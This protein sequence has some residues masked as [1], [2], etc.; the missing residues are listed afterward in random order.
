MSEPN[1]QPAHSDAAVPN[2]PSPKQQH[3]ASSPTSD[4]KPRKARPRW[5]RRI[6]GGVVVLATFAVVLRV[7]LHFAL[8]SVIDKVAARYGLKV[9]FERQELTL[10]GGDA[11]LWFVK[12]TPMAGGEPV[13][14][15]DYV[16]GDISVVQLLM[17]RLVVWRV[18]G[19]GVELNI[20][21][22]ADGRI[23]LLE[24]FVSTNTK[25]APTPP[26]AASK[27]AGD[28]KKQIEFSSP[29]RVDALRLNRVRATIRDKSVSPEFIATVGM[30]V[31]VSDV[32]SKNRP[33]KFELEVM[34]DPLLDLLHVEG[35]ARSDGPRKLDAN[36]MVT[37]RGLHLRPAEPYLLP[38]GLRP[39][40]DSMTAQMKARLSTEAL[41]DPAKGVSATL[42][43]EEIS[44]RS[45][46]SEAAA[47]DKVELKADS[48]D[49]SAAKLASLLVDG[50]RLN[51]S[52]SADGTLRFAGIEL[53]PATPAASASLAES[54]P[55]VPP[56]AGPTTRPVPYQ[57]R[58]A[59]LR[60]SNVTAR[61]HDAAVSPPAELALVV[62][63]L[64]SKDVP[65]D[66]A[67]PEAT[68]AVS[69]TFSVP[70]VVKQIQLTGRLKPYAPR[71]S[72]QMSIAG[73]GVRPDA[74]RP[75][76]DALGIESTIQSGKFAASVDAAV[77]LESTGKVVAD[78]ILSDV[79]LTDIQELI[80]MKR[81][82]IDSISIDPQRD[83]LRVESI[84]VAGPSLA[85]A[86]EENGAI[87]AVG[88]RL[89]PRRPRPA[90]PAPGSAQEEQSQELNQRSINF[91]RIEIGELVWNG[92]KV[93]FTDD[94]AE[95]RRSLAIADAGVKLNNLVID[96]QPASEQAAA[97]GKFRAW[98]KSP[99]VAERL[100][101]SGELTPKPSG[102]DIT[103]D[104]TGEGLSPATL[105]PYL[106]P[107]GVEP[108]LRDG[109]LKLSTTVN[110]SKTDDA[111]AISASV[112]NLVYGTAGNELVGL[113]GLAISNLVL[114]SEG[115]SVDRIQV[116]RPRAR[117]VRDAAGAVEVA[118]VRIRS[119]ASSPYAPSTQPTIAVETLR[120]PA[121]AADAAPFE[122]PAVVLRELRLNDAAIAWSDHG[123]SPPVQTTI[124]ASARLD[125]FAIGQPTDDP[126]TFQV[127]VA[128]DG[129]MDGLTLAGRMN[130]SVDSPW[131]DVKIEAGGL[132]ASQL[133]AYLPAGAQVTL[134]DGRFRAAMEAGL[135]RQAEGGFGVR[136]IV[137][138]VDY[139]DGADGPPLFA[140]EGVTLAANRI[141]VPGGI[142]AIDEIS[143]AGVETEARRSTDGAI[144]LLGV[145]LRS[146][147]A[148]AP[149]TARLV[150]EPQ[151]NVAAVPAIQPAADVAQIVDQARKPMPTLTIGK[152]DLNLK[153]A[154]VYD[155]SRPDAAP[156]ALANW[157]LHTLAPI[158]A[159]GKN[160]EAAPPIQMELTGRVDPIVGSVAV[161]TQA[162]PFA[163]QPSAQVDVALTGIRGQGLTDLIPQLR[164]QLD[165][166]KLTDGQFRTRVEAAARFSRRGAGDLDLTRG[167]ELDLLV[168]DTAFRNG[169]DGP[170]LA[171]LESLQS[172]GIRVQPAS[173]SVHVKTLELTKPIGYVLRDNEGVHV[174]GWVVKLPKPA[175]NEEAPTL[176]AAE[177]SSVSAETTSVAASS[178][179][180]T[181]SSSS[182]SGEIRVDRLLVSG[183]DMTLEDRAVTPPMLVPLNGLDVEVRD[184]TNLALV[185]NRPIRFSAV[186]TAGKVALP[187]HVK[188]AG[189]AGAIGDVGAMLGGNKIEEAAVEL[190]QRDVF[191][192]I[193]GNGSISLYPAPAG[194]AKSSIS[195]LELAA[196]S[197]AASQAGVTL[198]DGVFDGTVDLRIAEDGN[199]DAKSK[200]VLTDLKMSEPENGPIARHIALPAPLDAVIGTVQD[201]GG[202]ITLP[203][204]VQVRQGELSGVGGAVAGAVS[205]VIATAFASAPAKAVGGV[206]D[207]VGLGGK[208]QDRQGPPPVVIAFAPADSALGPKELDQINAVVELMRKDESVQL[209]LKH[210]LGGG[211]VNL[212]HTRANPSPDD[213]LALAQKTRAHK[214]RLLQLRAQLIGQARSS[215]AVLPAAQADATLQQLREVEQELAHTEDALDELYG[216][217]RPGAD[218]QASRRTRVAALAIGQQRLEAVRASLNVNGVPH[219][220]ER[221]RMLNPQFATPEGD[222]AGQVV[223]T[224]VG[225]K[226]NRASGWMSF[227]RIPGLTK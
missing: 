222:D 14:A 44:A 108:T 189:I 13:L 7:A 163:Q 188:G 192:Q 103:A 83:L 202:A 186:L 65:L 199:I 5:R 174:L 36:M 128:V 89:D 153:R 138:D 17:G 139:R 201:S 167:F 215:L 56:T 28:A 158:E 26:N 118:G 30:D 1:A 24:Q 135:T 117:L 195:G 144:R 180:A 34:S 66:A 212:A 179:P 173:G 9:A 58:L 182:S 196:F 31:R 187:K 42:A 53:V 52:R 152:I 6:L 126:A 113:D 27:P 77:K 18:E 154:T 214:A 38:L 198:N 156:L 16:R 69:G 129:S 67:N 40:A 127:D 59:D 75:Y 148:E 93:D 49:F 32:G 35:E 197:G 136:L 106:Q 146:V 33:T 149:A 210:E 207:L 23:A 112:K 221:V 110:L 61:F 114:G 204:N 19:D 51:A 29:L 95:T 211:D 165:G 226:S 45:D 134:H 209:V 225:D 206:T 3:G 130:P 176:A 87:C 68:V 131:V 168:A 194:Y 64:T 71:K 151:P 2:G 119:A 125:E 140:L 86:R 11:G 8:P 121:S 48:V 105:A 107:F 41:A 100:E 220:A 170:V 81:M 115:T 72:L 102:L 111:F 47:V 62:N 200:F 99:G 80:A 132:R 223:V 224:F 90:S 213:C 73:E 15:A 43:L 22:S 133:A 216:M 39:T 122:L 57:V 116:D 85:V 184:L 88:F 109:A 171:G 97:P 227:L 54:E 21:R 219:A 92:V 4:A 82:A 203:V 91:P 60:V 147:P 79:M 70:N 159:G 98:L 177:V 55:A 94:A 123:V 145:E 84:E 190:E 37:M 155:D 120:G 142:F 74:I 205:S 25:P 175:A 162:A 78:A 178:E 160:A 166:A 12:V 46:S 150:A 101:A 208:E 143:V 217:L 183:I 137:K 76:L 96:L 10:L 50:V 185:E 20:E 193:A 164:D 218:R 172:D 157:R 124:H 191:S 104:V 181:G 161:K 169:A 141:D 63:E